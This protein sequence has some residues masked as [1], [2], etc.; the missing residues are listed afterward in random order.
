MAWDSDGIGRVVDEPPEAGLA[1]AGLLVVAGLGQPPGPRLPDQV[2]AA[3]MGHHDL[4]AE[5]VVAA[6]AAALALAAPH[7]DERQQRKQRVV[8]VGAFAQIRGVGGH[9]QI[10]EHRDVARGRRLRP[11]GRGGHCPVART[12]GDGAFL[13]GH[14]SSV[15]SR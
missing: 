14:D 7:A 13:G 6:G 9:R 4:L 2:V 12:A 3:V 10:G 11:F 1:Q 5:P 15:I 8:E